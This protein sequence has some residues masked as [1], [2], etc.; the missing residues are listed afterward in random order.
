[1]MNEFPTVKDMVYGNGKDM[2]GWLLDLDLATPDGFNLFND[3][4]QDFYGSILWS[5]YAK[6]NAGM[7]VYACMRVAAVRLTLHPATRAS[8]IRGRA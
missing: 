7:C 8:R 4:N 2:S 1:M 6:A 5:V 3:E